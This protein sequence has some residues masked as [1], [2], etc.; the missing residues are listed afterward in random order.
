MFLWTL[1][2]FWRNAL[3]YCC[4]CCSAHEYRTIYYILKCSAGL[5]CLQNTYTQR[6]DSRRLIHNWR[7]F[8]V[9]SQCTI[10]CLIPANVS[11]VCSMLPFHFPDKTRR[12]WE[13]VIQTPSPHSQCSAA[14]MIISATLDKAKNI[15]FFEL[16]SHV[17]FVR[18]WQKSFF[19]ASE[20]RG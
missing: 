7:E 15:H 1:Y 8:S 12:R 20:Y 4:C 13:L 5:S 6:L 10:Y 14:G 16:D 18:F 9:Y 19:K 11:T 17:S 2:V 3:Y